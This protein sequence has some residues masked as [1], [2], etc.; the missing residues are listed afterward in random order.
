[1]KVSSVDCRRLRKIIR[2][3]SGSCLVVDCRPYLSFTDS[4]IRGSVNVNL[5]SVVVRRS[6]GGPVPLHFVIPDESS[7]LRLREGSIS[8]IVALDDRTSHWQKLKKDSV[9]QI[10]INTLAHLASGTN[11]CFLKGGYENFHSQYPELCTEVKTIDQSGTETEKRGKPVEILPFLYLGSAYHASRQDYLSDLH[12]TALLN[13]SRRDQ[14]PAKGLYDYKWIPVEDSHMADISS[15]F[16]EAID[17]IDHVK[18]SG[19]KVLVHCEAGISRSPTICMAYIM[20]TQQLR[21]DEAF[22]IIK[23][24]RAVISPNFSFMGQLLQFESEVLS[25]APAHAATPEPATPCAQESASFFANDFNT[26][27]FEPCV[28]TLPTSCLQSPVH[29]QFKLSPITALP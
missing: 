25:M 1:M 21:L 7:L 22:D 26:K 23:Q 3:E 14:Q 29:H 2:K 24:R 16:Q 11:I 20:R 9:A 4:N 28:F 27:N 15:H 19:G 6:R 12:I 8:A 18:Q 10:V 13:V 17:F 5:N